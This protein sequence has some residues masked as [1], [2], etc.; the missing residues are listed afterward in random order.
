MSAEADGGPSA[1]ADDDVDHYGQDHHPRRTPM[2]ML[3]MVSRFV[4]GVVSRTAA[5]AHPAIGSRC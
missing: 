3:L 5:A 4:I 2:T 1:G